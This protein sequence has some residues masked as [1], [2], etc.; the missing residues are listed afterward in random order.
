MGKIAPGCILIDQSRLTVND[1]TQLPFI[2]IPPE[3]DLRRFLRN[4]K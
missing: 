1:N 3:I 4:R 2:L